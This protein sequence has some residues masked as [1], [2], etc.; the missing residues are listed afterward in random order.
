MATSIIEAKVIVETYVPN[1]TVDDSGIYFWAA[2][3]GEFHCLDLDGGNDRVIIRGGDYFNYCNGNL[4]YEGI[5]ENKNGPCHTIN[6]L[7]ITTDKT[8]ILIEEANEYFNAHGEWIGVMFKQFNE[9]PETISPELLK[10]NELGEI[11]VGYN[12]SVGY[13]YVA[14]E[15]LYMCVSL[16]ESIFVNGKLNCIARLDDG[17]TIWD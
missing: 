15:Y 13:V 7:N 16:R 3:R 1:V 11:F 4:Y 6:C 9:Y 12:E 14:G 17:V 2:D 10:Q 5:S 8:V